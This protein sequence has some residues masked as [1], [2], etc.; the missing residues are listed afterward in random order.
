MTDASRP[1]VSAARSASRSRHVWSP[2]RTASCSASISIAVCFDSD[3][4]RAASSASSI[5][6]LT[7]PSAAASQASAIRSCGPN[8]ATCLP[9]RVRSSATILAPGLRAAQRAIRL[10]QQQAGREAPRR[11]RLRRQRGD[12]LLHAGDGVGEPAA[13]EFDGADQNVGHTPRQVLAGRGD[14]D[15][16]G[17][18]LCGG[19]EVAAEH[20]RANFAERRQIA[21]QPV[22][23]VV[24]LVPALGDRLDL[25]APAHQRQRQRAAEHRPF[26]GGGGR[27]RV[28]EHPLRER[29]RPPRVGSRTAVTPTRHRRRPT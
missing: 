12:G 5:A 18:S 13:A 16:V 8:T 11:R 6:A 9:L 26:D 7:F 25:F 23:L 28:G 3:A 10:R 22:D 24:D 14:P 19:V 21:Q 4:S 1:P 15:D 27:V 20:E 17:G 2:N 29:R